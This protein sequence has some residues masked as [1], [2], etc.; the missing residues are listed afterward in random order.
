MIHIVTDSGAN[1]PSAIAEAH[2]I[3]VVPLKVNMGSTSYQ[4][5]VD[6]S[7]EQF[8]QQLPT[9]NPMPTTSQPSPADFEEVYAERLTMGADIVSVHLSSKL[10]GTYNSARTA[11]M[12][13]GSGRISV[14]DSKSASVGVSLLV[15]AAARMAQAGRSR[16][17]IVLH[18]ERMA[19]EMLLVL[20]LDTLEY[21][22]RGGRIGGARAFLGGLLKVKPVILLK[23]GVIEAGERARSRRKAID[24]LI[25]ME[26]DR[27]GKQPVWVGVAQAMADDVAE[28][29]ALARERLNVQ[30]LIRSDIGPVVATHT[31]PGTLGL[32]VVPA[33]TL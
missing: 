25:Q 3:K 23:N 31:G 13:L 5:G 4:E 18:L 29:E 2:N 8:F 16:Q 21:L 24:Q 30:E 22:R 7:N 1:L 11:A 32:A 6:L 15:L 17:E 12:T 14:I 9:A 19:D 28:L 27:F 10:S 33:P 20:T 26:A